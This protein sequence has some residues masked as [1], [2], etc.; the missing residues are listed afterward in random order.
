VTTSTEQGERPHGMN[1][2]QIG[3]VVTVVLTVWATIWFLWFM[4]VI[5]P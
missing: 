5:G 3:V 2:R 1:P 4:G